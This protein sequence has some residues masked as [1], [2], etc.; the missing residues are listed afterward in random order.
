MPNRSANSTYSIED[1][2]RVSGVPIRTIRFYQGKRA[3]PEPERKGRNAI[4]H[5][6][7]LERLRL[8]EQLQERGLS[9]KMIREVVTER[10]ADNKSVADWLGVSNDVFAMSRIDAPQVL[11]ESEVSELLQKHD[12]RTKK[13]LIDNNL[14]Q[15]LGTR[16]QTY[17]IE[18]PAQF[19]LTLQSISLGMTVDGVVALGEILRT[20]LRKAS[21]ELVAEIFTSKQN[22]FTGPIDNS[23]TAREYMQGMRNIA[24][25]GLPLLFLQELE[26]A[27]TV[28]F[29]KNV[30]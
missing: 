13:K 9:L 10:T 17:R 6:H 23:E 16:P 24:R 22:H 2:S 21:S 19:T 7:H 4:Y 3:L 28:H 14:L 29:A 18:S 30:D 5:E 15:P 25:E 20:H 11:S 26:R 1:L 12:A 8:I 27:L